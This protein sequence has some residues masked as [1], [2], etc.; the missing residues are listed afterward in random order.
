MRYRNLL[1]LLVLAEISDDYEEV[2]HIYENV[3]DRARRCQIVVQRAD[4]CAL[5]VDL[6]A[7]SLARAYNFSAPGPPIEVTGPLRPEQLDDYYF[8]STQSGVDLLQSKRDQWPFD[9]ED[10]LVAGWALPTGE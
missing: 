9:E 5:L 1:R 10:S 4:I 8:W 7:G 3:S 6:V 2:E